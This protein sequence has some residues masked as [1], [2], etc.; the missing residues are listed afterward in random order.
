MKKEFKSIMAFMGL[1]TLCADSDGGVYMVEAM[2]NTLEEKCGEAIASAETAVQNATEIAALK[3][4]IEKLNADH[5]AALEAKETELNAAHEAAIEA[6]KAEHTAAL[7]A[8][9][10]HLEEEVGKLNTEHTA[11][12]AAKDE[13][14]A[15][16]KADLAVSNEKV[17]ALEAQV[18][19]MAAVAPEPQVPAAAPAAGAAPKAYA[20]MT[21]AE[22]AAY[23]KE[24][25]NTRR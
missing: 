10:A 3:A 20:E 22:K 25:R 24:Q 11:A 8:A 5:A 9:N 12:L 1:E 2:V 13:E 14:L 23:M 17:T 19:E 18:A 7:D 21:T 16:A 15:T 4:Q 6:L